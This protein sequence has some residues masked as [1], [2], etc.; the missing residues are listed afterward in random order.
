MISNITPARALSAALGICA[1]LA[2]ASCQQEQA[3]QKAAGKEP[4]IDSTEIPATPAAA[5]A[6]PD[7]PAP[8]TTTS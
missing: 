5:P 8:T 4:A 6:K 2:L 3:T 1:L 7:P